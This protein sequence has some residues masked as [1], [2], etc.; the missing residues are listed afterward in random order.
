MSELAPGNHWTMGRK[1]GRAALLRL[2]DL[3]SPLLKRDQ[4]ELRM[5]LPLGFFPSGLSDL[6][7]SLGISFRE[8]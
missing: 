3:S 8:G 5:P 2:A 6:R 4:R 7:S 1:D